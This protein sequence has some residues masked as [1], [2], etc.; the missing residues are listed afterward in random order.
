MKNFP[1]SLIRQ[2]NT[3]NGLGTNLKETLLNTAGQVLTNMFGA[4]SSKASV[5]EIESRFNKGY[6]RGDIES[7]INDLNIIST[8]NIVPIEKDIR[9]QDLKLWPAV[10]NTGQASKIIKYKDPFVISNDIFS[11]LN[12][13]SY[14]FSNTVPYV[15]ERG[16]TGN[17]DENNDQIYTSII[18]NFV[19]P[20][21][22][23]PFSGISISGVSEDVPLIDSPLKTT[24]ASM[25]VGMGNTFDN[26]NDMTD[27]QAPAPPPKPAKKEEQSNSKTAS[28][29]KTGNNNGAATGGDGDTPKE[30]STQTPVANSNTPAQ[31]SDPNKGK[32]LASSDVGQMLDINEMKNKTIQMQSTVYGKSINSSDCS[33]QTLVELSKGVTKD[34]KGQETGKSSNV[35][36][37]LGLATYRYADFMFCK[38]LGKI[39]NN[40]LI[41]LRK[42]PG[43]IGDNIFSTAH[44]KNRQKYPLDTSAPD[45]GRLITWFGNEDNKLEDICKYNYK[46][47]WKQFTSEIDQKPSQQQDQGFVNQLANFLSP[48]NN[49]LIGAGFSGNSG[50]MHGIASFLHVPLISGSRAGS[51]YYDS[52]LM[53]NYDKH[54]IYEPQNRIWDT[55]KYEGRLTFNQ[56]I[57]L[58]FRYV[59]RSYMNINP[60]A[61]F[62][63]LIGNIQTVTYRRG[64]FWG[65]ENKIYGPQGNSSVYK[66]ANAFIDNA[67]DKLGGIWDALASGGLSVDGITSFL[68]NIWN[69]A[70]SG[71]QSILNGAQDTAQKIV[72]QSDGSA[73]SVAKITMD[74]ALAEVRK[75]M[76]AVKGLNNKYHWTDAMKGMIKNQLGRPAMYAFNSL[77]T[78]EPV[79]PWHLTIGNPRNPIMVMGNLILENSEVTHLGPLGLDDF[80]TELKVTV[81]LK[82]AMSRDSVGIQ[83]MYTKGTKAIH[84]PFNY[85]NANNYWA[86]MSAFPDIQGMSDGVLKQILGA[87]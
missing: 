17:K 35:G 49:R 26:A 85:I 58:T 25:N 84:L 31:N 62:L 44:P 51:A 75:T 83:K 77:L 42:F 7:K 67:F 8:T 6:V 70:Y 33:I 54:K 36:E 47:S 41:T 68:G 72:G 38:D 39:S 5:S 10:D 50:L 71:V 30:S 76:Y 1:S 78:G 40:H 45:I 3:K 64:S 65:G 23:N 32:L 18:E 66:K 46:A 57:T 61:A 13:Y 73:G 15:F 55:H 69:M 12:N 74:E 37:G 86:N 28:T 22:F 14:M 53:S 56:D 43:P 16:G 20:S 21:L 63:D 80:P 79:G 2:R 87:I 59:M 24:A 48:G 29:N 27:H 60:K 9:T 52:T 81:T 82:H 34:D 4:A 11:A 19:V